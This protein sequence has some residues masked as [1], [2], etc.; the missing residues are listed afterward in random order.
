MVIPRH[1]QILIYEQFNP[2]LDIIILIEFTIPI[3]VLILMPHDLLLPMCIATILFAFTCPHLIVLTHKSLEICE[4][5]RLRVI[6]PLSL[7]VFVTV[8]VGL[9]H[10]MVVSIGRVERSFQ[11]FSRM[12][13]FLLVYAAVTIVASVFVEIVFVFLFYHFSRGEGFIFWIL[14][15]V[16]G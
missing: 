16:F 11:G 10:L 14:H 4:L 13:F 6:R 5:F 15:L 8:W 9:M 12:E 7:K 3:K 1:L 2:G